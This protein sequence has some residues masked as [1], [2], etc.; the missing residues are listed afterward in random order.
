MSS[1][2]NDRYEAERRIRDRRRAGPDPAELTVP[3]GAAVL[4]G[5]GHVVL[6]VVGEIDVATIAR[7]RTAVEHAVDSVLAVAAGALVVDLEGVRFL[8]ARALAVLGD[9]ADRLQL[10]GAGLSVR[11]IRPYLTWVFE[12]TGMT[13]I[14]GIAPDEDTPLISALSAA[15][16]IPAVREVLDSALQLVV[17]MTHAVIGASDGASITLPRG[18][19]L[20]TAAAS[21]DVVL[22][23]DADQYSTG[24]GPCL[25]AATRG[26]RFAIGTLANETRWPSFVPLARARGIETIMSTPLMQDDRPIGALNIYSRT[27]EALAENEQ[28]WADQF[29]A[30]AARLVMA[31]QHTAHFDALG[32][33]IQHALVDRDTVTRAQ[34]LVM[35]RDNI[36]AG[37]ASLAL[38]SASRGSGRSLQETCERLLAEAA[39][40]AQSASRSEATDDRSSK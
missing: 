35:R 34:G 3:Y 32:K 27:A 40:T 12:V 17:T 18:G 11:G 25:D 37:A 15:A 22:G 24:E 20:R 10:W 39:R 36:S 16:S 4:V 30:E 14:L 7:F 13:R 8:D 5:D 21:N 38:R 6:T 26:E 33:R 19:R 28:Q 23:M 31:G 2:D 9:G 29:A 1:S